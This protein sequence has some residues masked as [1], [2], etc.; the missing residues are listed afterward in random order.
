MQDELCT[1]KFTL[2]LM[3]VS[4]ENMDIYLLV[5]TWPKTAKLKHLEVFFLCFPPI[6]MT[7]FFPLC[8]TEKVIILFCCTRC[9]SD[10][11]CLPL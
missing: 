11:N 5:F 7:I 1:V 4:Q 6:W 3:E 2:C 8:Y 9:E 10:L